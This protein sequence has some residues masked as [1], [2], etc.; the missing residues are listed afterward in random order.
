M[1]SNLKIGEH[2]PNFALTDKD[3][4]TVR[5]ADLIGKSAV[6][7][8]FYPHDNSAGCTAEACAFRDSYEAF[9][10]AGATVIGVSRD[11][12]ES[13]QSFA[14]NHRLP[15]ILLSDP[16]GHVHQLYGVSKIM[17]FLMSRETFVID[18]QGFIRHHFTSQI[19]MTKHVTEALQVIQSLSDKIQ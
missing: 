16:D 10:A 6:V 7:L 12:V 1:S 2:A 11:S 13:H 14:S 5:L 19:N 8:Y 17:G 4:K 15:F 18:N 9:T 3:G